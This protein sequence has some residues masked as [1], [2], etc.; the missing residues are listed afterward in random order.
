[1]MTEVLQSGT[2]TSIAVRADEQFPSKLTQRARR[3][4]REQARCWHKIIHDFLK[5]FEIGPTYCSVLLLENQKAL[6]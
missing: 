6:L 2:E 5:S 1:M 4:N 3:A